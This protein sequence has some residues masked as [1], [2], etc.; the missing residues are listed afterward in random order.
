MKRLCLLLALLRACRLLCLSFR[1]SAALLQHDLNPVLSLDA[2]QSQLGRYTVT[3]DMQPIR[4]V[5]ESRMRDQRRS[6]AQARHPECSLRRRQGYGHRRR[7]GQ[8]R[9]MTL[10]VMAIHRSRERSQIAISRRRL[11]LG[12]PHCFLS[13]RSPGDNRAGWGGNNVPWQREAACRIIGEDNATLTT[14][15]L[16]LTFI[17]PGVRASQAAGPSRKRAR[18]MADMRILCLRFE[19]LLGDPFTSDEYGSTGPMPQGS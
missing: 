15:L 2:S 4:S 19:D 1:I 3:H 16:N 8:V 10:D 7:R 17:W 11:W 12:T 9:R 18:V 6:H 5:S 14:V 13:A